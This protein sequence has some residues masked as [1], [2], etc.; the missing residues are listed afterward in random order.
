MLRAWLR[1]RAGPGGEQGSRSRLS[2]AGRRRCFVE[3]GSALAAAAPPLRGARL[4]ALRGRS[5]FEAGR[6]RCGWRWRDA[7]RHQPAGCRRHTR[8]Q[9]HRAAGRRAAGRT[10]CPRSPS[11]VAVGQPAVGD[12]ARDR[13]RGPRSAGA[14]PPAAR[15]QGRP[16]ARVDD[17]RPIR[18]AAA[19]ALLPRITEIQ[20]AQRRPCAGG[21]L[22]DRALAAARASGLAAERAGLDRRARSWNSAR[23]VAHPARALARRPCRAQEARHARDAGR[24]PAQRRNDRRRQP[25]APLVLRVDPRAS[26]APQRRPAVCATSLLERIAILVEHRSKSLQNHRTADKNRQRPGRPSTW[27][28]A[29]GASPTHAPLIRRRAAPAARATRGR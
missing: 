16:I 4:I 13:R 20:T 24:R 29:G 22:R 1:R 15:Q 6:R 27:P 17:Q 8:R 3:H 9:H 23:P 21:A 14:A 7:G 11:L 18:T 12:R 25:A 28:S 10:S 19:I 2:A 26:P 5:R